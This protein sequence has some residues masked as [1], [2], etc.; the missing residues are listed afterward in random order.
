MRGMPGQVPP[1]V[2][3]IEAFWSPMEK[4]SVLRTLAYSFVGSSETV[5]TGLKGFVQSMQPDELIVTGHFYDHA[6][7]L[8]SFEILAELWP[9]VV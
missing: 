9:R 4:A 5:E 6:A 3:D 2:E 1:P 7:R 8:Q